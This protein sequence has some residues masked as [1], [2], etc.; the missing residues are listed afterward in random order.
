MKKNNVLLLLLLTF[1]S[2]FVMNLAISTVE[3]TRIRVLKTEEE[4]RKYLNDSR[5]AKDN[6]F[7]GLRPILYVSRYS[8]NCPTDPTVTNVQPGSNPGAP[9]S[10]FPLEPPEFPPE[11]LDEVIPP[12]SDTAHPHNPRLTEHGASASSAASLPPEK[13]KCYPSYFYFMKDMNNDFLT[14]YT[15][16]KT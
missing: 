14:C 10:Q 1:S 9:I 4:K 5:I 12:V 2:Y 15:F 3:R 11:E 7:F 6:F 13:G 16:C 8:C